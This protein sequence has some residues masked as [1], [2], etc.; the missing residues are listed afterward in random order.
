MMIHQV[1]DM[2]GVQDLSVISR[3]LGV[4]SSLDPVIV[5][6]LGALPPDTL[7]EFMSGN[8]QALTSQ[9]TVQHLKRAISSGEVDLKKLQMSLQADKWL[10]SS[11]EKAKKNAALNTSRQPRVAPPPART[12]NVRSRSSA[13][14]SSST[15][16]QARGGMSSRGSGTPRGGV[17]SFR[18]RGGVGQSGGGAFARKA[19]EASMSRRGSTGGRGG[20]DR[21]SVGGRGGMNRDSV[22]GRGGMN[23]GGNIPP[24]I[25]R[26]Y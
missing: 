9:P 1:C 7:Q 17:S 13:S 4:L 20:M 15:P 14:F 22:G 24:F 5:Q 16:H 6:T 21:G 25:G 12:A 19:F 26:R 2:T 23:R 11:S 10:P 8:M 3:A 18:G